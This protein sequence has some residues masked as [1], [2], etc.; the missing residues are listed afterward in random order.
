MNPTDEDLVAAVVAGDHAAFDDLMRRYERLV[1][2]LV[3]RAE[4]GRED[5]LDAT[6]AVFLKAFRGLPSF[7]RESSF[8]TWLLRIAH[9]EGLNQARG[10]RREPPLDELDSTALRHAQPA[11]QETDLVEAERQGLVRRALATLNGRHR[12]AVH[13]RYL[14]QWSIREIA[15]VLE[16]SENT[17]KNI[18][19]RGVRSLR[20]AVEEMGV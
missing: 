9:R 3:Y 7:R 10:F 18:L 15:H 14:D 17:T 2:R 5:A 8:K 11:S 6:Q 4:R 13:L 16:T 19:F 20:R 1:Y 12:T